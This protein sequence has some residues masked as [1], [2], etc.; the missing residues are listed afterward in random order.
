MASNITITTSG[1]LLT[2]IGATLIALSPLAVHADGWEL[3]T[4]ME[5]FP[6]TREIE[7]GYLEEGIS[8][9]QHALKW[10]GNDEEVGLLSN[11]CVGYILAQELETAKTY[12]DSAVQHSSPKSEGSVVSINNL[13]VLQAMQ[14]NLQSAQVSFT[15]AW[16]LGCT[17]R[18]AEREVTSREHPHQVALR[19]LNRIESLTSVNGDGRELAN[20]AAIDE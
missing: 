6:G 11:L 3:T 19:N 13:G 17:S 12:C 1:A 16:E 20:S 10:P 2:T 4:V 7:A 9:S 8:E 18:C 15:T 5:E 14:G